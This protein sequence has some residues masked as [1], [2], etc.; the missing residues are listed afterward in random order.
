MNKPYIYKL[1]MWIFLQNIQNHRAYAFTCV[2][3][4]VQ[5]QVLQPNKP[6]NNGFYKVE[7]KERAVFI[8]ICVSI[9]CI[10]IIFTNIRYFQRKA[11]KS[12]INFSAFYELVINF[13]SFLYQTDFFSPEHYFLRKKRKDTKI[14][15]V[16]LHSFA[17]R[18][19]KIKFHCGENFG[20]Y[21]FSGFSGVEGCCL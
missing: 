4:W 2:I 20:A 21:W 19:W 13:R 1:N 6:T 16:S 12:S 5:F 9:H 18:K 8:S 7:W 11:I 15:N 17:C 3:F 14:L 10:H